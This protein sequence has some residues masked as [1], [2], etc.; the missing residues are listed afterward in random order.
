[1]PQFVSHPLIN[2]NLIESRLYQ[3]ILVARILEKGNSL[4]V[5]PTALGKTILAVMVSAFRLEKFAGEKI[6]LMAPTR[7]LAVQHQKTFQRL[8]KIPEEEIVLITGTTSPEKRKETYGNAKIICATPQCIENDLVNDRISLQNF[9]TCFF[10][11]GHRAVGDYSYIYIAQ[12]YMKHAKNP[13]IV[14]LTAS[15]G[16]ETEKIQDLCKSLFIENVEVKTQ[17]DEDVKPYTN[18]IE[19][20]WKKV[21]L[22]SEFKEII[23]LLKDFMREKIDELKKL[24]FAPTGNLNYY[25]GKRLLELQA[26]VR[27]QLAVRAKTQP[28]LFAAASKIAAIINVSHALLLLETQGVSA[29][30][31][32]FDRLQKKNASA[33]A[34]KAGKAVLADEGIRKAISLTEKLHSSGIEHPKIEE[35]KKILRGQFL[36]NPQSRIIVFNHYRDSVKKLVEEVNKVEGVLAT[37]FVGQAMKDSGKG[38]SQKEQIEAIRKF[39]EGEYNVLLA[40]SVAEEGLD[41][42]VC[43]LVIFYEPV[44]SEIRTIQRR[45]RTGRLSKG[46]AIM[47]MAAGTRDEAYHWTA[48]NKE[49]KMLKN[50]KSIKKIGLERNKQTTLQ[51]FKEEGEPQEEKIIVYADT[52]E[53]ASSVIKELKEKGCEIHVMQL[54]VGDYIVSDKVVIERKSVEDF[55]TSLLDGRL[56]N[57]LMSMN[58]NYE[59]PLVIVEGNMD[60]LYYSRNI[61]KNALLGALSSIA[62]EY[63][64]PVLFS[65]D[66]EET[67][68]FVYVIAKRFQ[69]GK[70]KDIRL[71][72]GKA[73]FSLPQQQQFIIESFPMIGPR[74]AKYLLKEFKT[75]KNLVN[76]SE[77]DL[78]NAQNIGKKKAKG[79]KELVEA[80][81]DEEK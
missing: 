16:A 15:P 26:I 24:G 46:K 28:S 68:E 75:I 59:M 10:D 62:L 13:L 77:K 66:A 12:Q 29:L 54:E 56:F 43:D 44:P 80:E 72:T 9:C 40:T 8:L 61:H 23:V 5:A 21:E 67:A 48:V 32:Y 38:M 18:E 31:S 79:I 33:K 53:Q 30:H 73:H 50:L 35:L 51:S 71:R 1:M 65:K 49:K 58:A 78:E 36:A 60:E 55:L 2:E 3:E 47:L 76:A 39:K 19:L 45:G 34:T 22:P 69:L 17:Q 7:P 4:I 81:Y 25:S 41:I 27:R 6:L 57:Q 37:E 14:A 63:R 52:R 11:E 20:V 42:P 64:T 70:D 74:T